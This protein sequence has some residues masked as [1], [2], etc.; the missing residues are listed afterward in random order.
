M[1]A[2]GNNAFEITW[3]EQTRTGLTYN[4]RWWQRLL[5]W[6]HHLVCLLFRGHRR[7]DINSLDDLV[8]FIPGTGE[9]KCSGCGEPPA[10]CQCPWHP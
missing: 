3:L 2:L 4:M 7:G 1:K 9:P 10:W 6:P 5:A 8:R